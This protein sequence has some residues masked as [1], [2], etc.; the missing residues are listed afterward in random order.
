[1]KDALLFGTMGDIGETALDNLLSH[2]LDASLVNF[3]QNIFRDEF[4]YRRLLEKSVRETEPSAVIPIG[5]PL[6]LSRMKEKLESDY[7]G[8]TVIT[9]SEDKLRLLDS[10]L[11]FYIFAESLGIRQPERL[12]EDY[13]VTDA[14]T[15]V[16]KRD[17][18]FGGH[19]VHLV[20][21]DK[22]IRN[23]A[24]HQRA[25]EPF[26]LERY[27]ENGV[28]WSV[29]ALRFPDGSVRTSAYRSTGTT[30]R[31][32]PSTSRA[33]TAHPEMEAVASLVMEKMDFHG[34]CGFDFIV[35]PDGAVYLLECNPRFTGG[36]KTQIDAGFEL[37]WLLYGAF[38]KKD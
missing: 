16:F 20:T 6:A 13:H 1:M 38:S 4:G 28:N 7:P 17:V 35:G 9:E 23:L 24:D 8:M 14:E 36:L 12:K 32:G 33:V 22:A 21:S 15:V 10:K 37:P 3:P 34:L 29:D 25:G 26:L 30:G 31:N 27:I 11:Q 19:G 5:C 18:S 2:G